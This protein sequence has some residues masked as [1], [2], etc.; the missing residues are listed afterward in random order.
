M[1]VVKVIQATGPTGTAETLAVGTTTT[2]E[3]GTNA[4]V[5]DSGGS[6]NHVFDFV[7]PK[8]FDGEDGATG[9]TGPTGPT[10]ATSKG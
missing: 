6:P 10:G 9:P 2:G 4:S 3:A 7:I 1:C 8:G 5:T